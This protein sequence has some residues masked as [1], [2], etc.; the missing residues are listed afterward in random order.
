VNRWAAIALALVAWAGATSASANEGPHTRASCPEGSVLSAPPDGVEVCAPQDCADDAD[1]GPGRMCKDRP[2]CVESRGPG[3]GTTKSAV[4]TC[5]S[6]G[7]CTYPAQCDEASKRCVR[8]GLVERYRTSCGCAVPGLG[9]GG[10]LAST[11]A[12]A[13][14]ALLG[15]RRGRRAR[16]V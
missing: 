1:C 3:L 15:A 16:G 2:L 13:L 12:I 9:E 10:G 6:G 4:G 11:A 7:S 8:A 5:E 14:A